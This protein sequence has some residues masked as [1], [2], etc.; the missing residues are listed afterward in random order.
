[1]EVSKY[2]GETE[3]NLERIFDKAKGKDWIL[4]FDEADALF[5]KRSSASNANDRFAKQ[6]VSIL[7]Q[8]MERFNGL[9]IMSSN[10][11]NNID[12]AFFRHFQLVLDFE[13]PDGHQRMLLWQK[14]K[15]NEFE[16]EAKVDLE[17]LAKKYELTAASIINT[18]HYCLLKCL[19]RGDR[20]I[21]L[22][23]IMKGI[24]IEMRKERKSIMS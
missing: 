17:L 6:E 9:V 10:F 13:K 16:Y 11:K 8:L 20:T 5:G 22:H 12:E 23:D 4:F 14:S 15:T 24:K 2:I 3:K 1:M 19:N 7:L 18:L 21:L